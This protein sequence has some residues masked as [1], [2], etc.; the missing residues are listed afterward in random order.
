MGRLP[1]GMV[2]PEVR[3][4]P[5]ARDHLGIAFTQPIDPFW[6]PPTT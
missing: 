2:V 5:E 6:M 3:R 4:V 1:A